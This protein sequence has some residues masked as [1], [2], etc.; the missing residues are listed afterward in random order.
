MRKLF[1]IGGILIIIGIF[2]FVSNELFFLKT[3]FPEKIWIHRVNSIEKLKEVGNEFSGIELDVVWDGTNFDV[4][5]P[6]AAS[7]GLKLDEYLGTHDD[8]RN[9]VIWLDF[10]NLNSFNESNSLKKLDSIINQSSFTKKSII[11]ESPNP[12]FLKEFSRNGFK[13]S[14]YLPRNLN[15][16]SKDSLDEVVNTLKNK[17]KDASINFL[18]FPIE[19]YE[20]VKKNFG[21]RDLLIWELSKPKGFKNKLRLYKALSDNKVKGILLPFKSN[22]DR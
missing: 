5:H 7:I 11:V 12:E 3:L 18:S 15:K 19:D 22:G 1:I 14:Y 21:N 17:V 2:Y 9:T 16:L 20:V 6:P 13:T 8:S 10:K 4:N